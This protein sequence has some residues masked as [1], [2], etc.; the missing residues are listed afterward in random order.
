MTRA[1][2]TT[3]S[4]RHPRQLRENFLG[5]LTGCRRVAPYDEPF[6][7]DDGRRAGVGDRTG[8]RM[9]VLDEDVP[10]RDVGIGGDLGDG[11]MG[12]TER[13]AV[14]AG[15]SQSF[16]E[17]PGGDHFSDKSFLGVVAPVNG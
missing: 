3:R 12:R 14:P 7:V 16:R 1:V 6:A 17:R 10:L 13:E 11:L 9:V 2:R 8:R 5:V 4:T 15:E